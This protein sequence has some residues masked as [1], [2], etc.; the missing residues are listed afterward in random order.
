MYTNIISVYYTGYRQAMAN[1]FDQMEKAVVTVP[2]PAPEPV[3]L[4]LVIHL[5]LIFHVIVE[6]LLVACKELQCTTG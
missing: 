6:L 5:A 4:L 3:G 1:L 2:R